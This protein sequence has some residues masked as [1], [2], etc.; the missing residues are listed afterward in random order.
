MSNNVDVLIIGGGPSGLTAATELRERSGA[1]VVVI[2]REAEAGGIPRHS[3][4][5][6]YGMRD[7]HTFISGPR[8]AKR[9]VDRAVKAGVDI[10]T[11]TMVT[12]WN[13]EDG[14]ECVSTRGLERITAKATLL[15]TGARERPRPA[16]MVPGDRPAGVFTTGELQNLVHMHHQK[17]GKRAVVIGGELV[18][19]SAVLTLRESG[20]K[21][22]GMVT[23][24][25][26]AESYGVFNM[27]GKVLFGTKVHTTSKVTRIIGKGRVSGVEIEDTRTG[28]RSII[29]CDTVVFTGDWIPDHELARSAGLV[30]DPLTRGPLVDALGRTSQ[31]GVFA[32]GNSVHPVDTADVAALGGKHAAGAIVDYLN[33]SAP[34]WETGVR[35]EAGAPFR[36][37]SPGWFHPDISPARGKLLAWVEEERS[38][39]AAVTARQDGVVIGRVRVPWPATPGRVFRVPWT[40]FANARADGGPITIEL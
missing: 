10:R 21:T 6:G 26:R 20:C 22:V 13:A 38:L 39:P 23:Q 28:S 9:L 8:Y 15:A 4:H 40:L 14:A 19:W 24:Y 35:L 33:G 12:S 1:H 5:P 2:D 18:S 37:I 17:P 16:R 31:A 11:S 32:A 34:A 7:M 25:P 30:L 36:W 3:D 29:E 27:G